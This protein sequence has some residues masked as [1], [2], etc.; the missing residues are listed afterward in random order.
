MKK[1]TVI[2]AGIAGLATAI[3]LQASGYEVEI[4]EKNESPGGKMHQI[5]EDGYSFDVGPTIVMMPEIYQELFSDVGRNYQ[6]YIEF[7]RLDP[8]YDVYFKSKTEYRKYEVTSDLVKLTKSLEEKGQETSLGFLT[9]LSTIYKRYLVALNHF[10]RRPF[11]K[12]TDFYNPFMLRQALKLKTFDSAD[13]MMVKFI[14]NKDFR[15]MMSFQTLYIGVSPQKGPSLY[16]IIPMIELLYG[17]YMLKGGMFSYAKALEKLFHELGGKIH[18][19]AEVE[20]ILIREKRAVGI[21]ANSKEILSD[22]VISNVDFP[23]T[24]KYLIKDPKAKG[25]YTDQKIDKMEYSCSCLVFYWA[26][27][28]EYK[29]LNTHNFFVTEDLDDNLKSIFDGSFL[30]DPSIYLFIPSKSD[31]SLAPKGKSAFYILMPIS[32]LG[33]AQYEFNETTINK[34]RE[35]ILSTLERIPS[36]KEIRK[37]IEKEWIYTPSDFEKQFSA[38]RGATFSLQPTLTQSNHLRPQAKSTVVE[39]LYFTGSG[40][41][42]GAGVPIVLES[43]KICASELRKDDTL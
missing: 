7:I 24:M 4:Y 27:D 31:E 38:Y 34:Y 3:R 10:I 1:V 6:D 20:E 13:K 36:L 17:I 32:N 14:P 28:G 9:F 5:K 23:Y 26:V 35:S 29:E 8:M 16:N 43:G 2:G 25:K 21:K 11:R 33:T 42:P 37:N 15:Q 41:H 18:Y 40:T 12:K 30:N 39:A 19:R 22:Y